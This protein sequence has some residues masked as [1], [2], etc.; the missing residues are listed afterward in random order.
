MI[1]FNAELKRRI[2]LVNAAYTEK[3]ANP[4][5][6]T[7]LADKRAPALPP[8]PDALFIQVGRL[9]ADTCLDF[10]LQRMDKAVQ[11]GIKYA[12]RRFDVP[13]SF[14]GEAFAH[15]IKN[16]FPDNNPFTCSKEE[17]LL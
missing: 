17:A 5:V 6:L 16:N 11:I 3:K 2:D 1:D 12:A 4:P 15:A 14:A 8:A 13:E 10:I 7:G 9:A